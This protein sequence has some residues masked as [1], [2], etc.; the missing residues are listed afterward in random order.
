MI[1]M[2]RSESLELGKYAE[3][4]GCLSYTLRNSNFLILNP[5]DNYRGEEEVVLGGGPHYPE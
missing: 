4:V 5:K 2:R 3:I 1:K